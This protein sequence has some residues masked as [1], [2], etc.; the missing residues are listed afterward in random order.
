MDDRAQVQRLAAFRE[1]LR[2]LE[3]R[4]ELACAAVGLTPQQYQL[5]VTVEGARD[6]TGRETIG[7]IAGRMRIAQ[8]SATG[9]VE[10]AEAAGLVVRARSD[11]DGRVV[12]VS[13]TPGGR[14]RLERV[15]DRLEDEREALAEAAA[16]LRAHL[17]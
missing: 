12:R 14:E 17:G 9:L 8:S 16:T 4:T 11:R 6:G 15:F 10:R 7:G 2:S 13:L 3:R 5:L 1:A